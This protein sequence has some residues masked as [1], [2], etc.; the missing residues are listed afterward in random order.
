LANG[1][2][3]TLARVPPRHPLQK[4]QKV[5]KSLQTAGWHLFGSARVGAKR[6]RSQKVRLE[7]IPRPLTSKTKSDAV[8]ASNAGAWSVQWMY[9]PD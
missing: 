5:K 3:H 2:D 8:Q 1:L 6:T 9:P 7:Q 4:G